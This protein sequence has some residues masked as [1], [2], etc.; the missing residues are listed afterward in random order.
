M[1]KKAVYFF[2]FLICWGCFSP[3]ASSAQLSPRVESLIENSRASNAFWAVQVR[4]SNGNLLED[5]NGDKLIRPASNLKLISSATFLDKLGSYYRFETKLYGRGF[6]ENGVWTGDLIVKGSGDPSINGIFYDDNPLYV[7]EKW[8]R[9]LKEKGITKI[10]GQLIGFDGL[11]DDVPYPRG[12]EW[13]DLSYYYAPEISALSFNSNVVD[14][15]VRADGTVGSKPDI[16]WFPF[17]TSYVEF[18]NEQI[19]TP[20]GSSFDESY[21]RILGTNTILLRSTLPQG[22]TETEP[23]AVHNPSAYFMDTFSKFLEKNGIDV[24]GRIYIEN[25]YYAWSDEHLTL[26]DVHKSV[27]L[28]K[29][30]KRLNQESDNFFAEMLLK[31]VASSEFDVQGTTELGLQ[32]MKE[33]MHSMGFDTLAV[34]L[35]DGSGMAPATLVNAADL[36]RFLLNIRD[37]EYFPYLFDSLANGGVNGTLAH[38][39][40]NSS[41]NEQFFGKTGFVS[42][43]RALSGFL[44]TESG[45]QLA[46]TII[47]NNYAVRTS[48][49][50]FIHERIVEYLFENY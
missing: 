42:G 34:S 5:L 35:R 46:V 16:T 3:Q 10:D 31:K 29:M 14:L 44:N 49:V 7:F 37:K 22:Y 24:T 12:W 2:T 15:E 47:T 45:Q 25:D 50:D 17:N 26:F 32:V 1:L 9:V 4:D 23:L 43:V 30:M 38:R 8:F 27:P 19:I 41:A 13:D 33:Y 40:R 39:F 48:H 18:I 21:R 20:P 36:N 6:L 11:F 28:H